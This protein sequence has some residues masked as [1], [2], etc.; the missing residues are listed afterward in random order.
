MGLIGCHSA[1]AGRVV[2]APT[3]DEV[4]ASRASYQCGAGA[5]NGACKRKVAGSES[6]V[7]DD[8]HQTPTEQFLHSSFT[9]SDAFCRNI[10]LNGQ[11]GYKTFSALG[12]P[13][14]VLG[15]AGTAGLTAWAAAADQDEKSQLAIGVAGAAASAV[16][17]TLGAFLIKRA[18]SAAKASGAAGEALAPGLSD[19]ARWAACLTARKDYLIGNASA[20]LPEEKKEAAGTDAKSTPKWQKDAQAFAEWASKNCK[21]KLATIKDGKITRTFDCSAMTTAPTGAAE[22]YIKLLYQTVAAFGVAKPTAVE[23]GYPLE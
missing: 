3:Q 4:K 14:T 9:S 21:E 6:T 15:A 19:E 23:V 11:T 8:A 16:V 17:T 22:D 1:I 13:T 5:T 20:A 2:Q 10:M 12:I 18:I 7:V